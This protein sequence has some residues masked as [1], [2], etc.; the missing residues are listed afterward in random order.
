[1]RRKILGSISPYL[2]LVIIALLLIFI[3]LQSGMFYGSE[4]DWYSQHVGIAESLRATMLETG[5][6]IPQYINLGG[7]SSIYDFSYYGVLRPDIVISC[8]IPNVEMKYIISAYA[9]LGIISSVI[10]CYGW[11]KR[12]KITWPFAFAGAVLFAAAACFYQ[13]HH[14]IMFVNYMPFL[15]LALSGVDRMMKKNKTGCLIVSLVMI[16]LHSFYYAIACLMVVLLYFLHRRK[17][18]WDGCGPDWHGLWKSVGKLSCAIGISIG[19]AA[20]LLIPTGLNILS[21]EKDAGSFV[22]DSMQIVDLTLEGLL[23][24]PY[25][26]GMTALALY[27]LLLSLTKKRRRFL[28]AAVLV[29]VLFPVAALVLNGFL[30]SRA[31]ILIPFL[32]LIILLCASTLQDLYQKKQKALLIPL[33]LCGVP[34]VCSEWN[35]L[36]WADGAILLGWCL[37]WRMEEVPNRIKRYTFTLLFLAPICVNLC[38]NQNETYLQSDDAR[39]SHFTSEEITAFASKDEY[40]FDVLANNFVNSNLLADGSIQKTAMY[41]SI[42]NQTY[43]QFYYD[44]M[45]NPISI[46]NRVALLPDQNSFFNY[47]MGIRYLLTDEEHLPYSY[48]AVSQKGTYVL[49]ENE[50]VL[51]VCYGTSNLLSERDY[52]K[53]EFPDTL[54]ALCTRA[55]VA[56]DAAGEFQFHIE[57]IAAADLFAADGEQKILSPSGKRE[58]STLP[59]AT[60][61]QEKILIISFQVESQG[62]EVI[63]SINGVKN[64]LSS[65]HA[66][67]PNHNEVFTY[68]LPA[69]ESLEELKIEFSKGNYTVSDLKIYTMD[70][71]YL[72]HSG[73]TE[74]VKEN[75]ADVLQGEITMAQAGYFIT[76]YPYR[77]GYQIEVDGCT[78]KAEKVNTAFIGFPIQ[79]GTHQIKIA[80]EAPEFRA[81]YF[82]SLISTGLLF[83][84]MMFEKIMNKKGK[85]K[86]EKI[87]ETT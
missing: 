1:M 33:L 73:I 39:Q 38:V 40:R 49:A 35:Y 34:I 74:P 87:I 23:Y 14:Q 21:T 46:N 54:E 62:R 52:E 82:I 28:A 59:L 6:L 67:Y 76:S 44:T 66:P 79:A 48:Q 12:Q 18:Q 47:F 69:E 77:D 13:A 84:L 45:R 50:N 63:I 26:C 42:T 64:K 83:L 53:L 65:E 80:Y 24:T 31:K 75:T 60:A 10:L 16:Y 4:G 27:C 85:Y 58:S 19:M 17:E 5:K 32:P 25:G 15:I 20:V 29:C 68:V 30:Y 37:I 51:P 61:L 78:V 71:R 70:A 72:E 41:S 55:V 3:P 81:G 57:E 2:L 11:L 56:A 36:L 8:L 43:A 22:S 9:I 86:N 7:G